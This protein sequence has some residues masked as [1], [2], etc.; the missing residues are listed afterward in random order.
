LPAVSKPASGADQ[1]KV[2]EVSEYE[3]ATE[4]VSYEEEEEEEE[5]VPK[6][7]IKVAQLTPEEVESTP[8]GKGN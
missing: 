8:M 4:E 6:Q 3:Y 7:S 2:K 5:D 1:S